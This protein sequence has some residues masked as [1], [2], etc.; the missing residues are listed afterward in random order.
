MST[1]NVIRTMSD[2]KKEGIIRIFGKTIEV[3]DLNKLEI[4]SKRG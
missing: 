3:V 4:I 2:F 1:A